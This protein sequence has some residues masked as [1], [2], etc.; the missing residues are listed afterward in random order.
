[1]DGVAGGR[2]EVRVLMWSAHTFPGEWSVPGNT[3]KC[4][5][6]V[7]YNLRFCTD[8]NAGLLGTC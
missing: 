1:M 3:A 6:G 7:E 4:L 8:R 5:P 2:G